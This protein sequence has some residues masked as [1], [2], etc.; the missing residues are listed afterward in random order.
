MVNGK[1]V[2]D[3]HVDDAQVEAVLT[4]EH[5]DAAAATGEVQHLLPRHL[6]RTHADPF[7]LDAVVGTQEQVTR[8]TQLGCECLLHQTY[9]HGQLFHSS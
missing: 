9:L 6:A 5:V 7:A 8:V 4:A 1:I 3:A 2:V